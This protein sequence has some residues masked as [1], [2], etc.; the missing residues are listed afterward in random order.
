MGTWAWS[1][2]VT[3]PRI[4]TEKALAVGEEVELEPGPSRHIGSALRLQTGA[5]I[6]LFNGRGGEFQ[7]TISH[8]DRKRVR[9]LVNQHRNIEREAPL[10]VHLGI[11]VSRGDRMDWV[12][13]KATELGVAEISPLLSERTEVKLHG[14]RADK[15]IHHWQ[16]IA[17]SACEQ[18]GRNT[19][20]PIHPL[21][22]L[23]DWSQ[24]VQAHRKLVLHHREARSLSS[25][26]RPDSLALLIGPEGGLSRLEIESALQAGFDALSMG[27]RV[28]RT[29]TAPIAALAI[30]GHH[31]GDM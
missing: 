6:T 25:L 17:I 4:Y 23:A 27:P 31:W 10:G 29:E 18:C 22:K 15:K 28:L 16:Q 20:P 3:G 12:V 19:V 24:Q 8:G 5:D 26:K 7:A 13:Q 30:I 11:A 1:S 14:D 21:A 2:G 9:V